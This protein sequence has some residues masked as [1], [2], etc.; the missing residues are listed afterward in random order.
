MPTIPVDD[1]GRELYYE[2]TGAPETSTGDYTTV[3]FLHGLGV[4][5]A[6][7]RP[8]FPFAPSHNARF[9][10]VNSREYSGSSKFRPDELES[11]TTGNKDEQAAVISGLGTELAVF[12]FR[13]IQLREIPAVTRNPDGSQSGGVVFV[14]WSFGCV[15]L[16]SLLAHASDLPQDIRAGLEGYLR[17]VVAYDGSLT[18]FGGP[19]PEGLYTPFRDPSIP[20]E[21]KFSHFMLLAS[22]YQDPVDNLDHVSIPLLQSRTA[23]R[24]PTF[25]TLTASDHE[26]ISEPSAFLAWRRILPLVDVLHENTT[27]AYLNPSGVWKDVQLRV[28]WTDSSA[29]PLMAA[30][31]WLKDRTEEWDRASNSQTRQARFTKIENA[32]HFVHWD[33]PER[34]TNIL[35]S[36]LQ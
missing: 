10:T 35:M 24:E 4:N 29:W 3:V 18:S 30:A 5:S 34:F 25:K 20:P 21:H 16:L 22:A 1:N 32:N 28:L 13:F 12:L 19:P 31:K 36:V 33:E 26:T 15:T 23:I 27:R 9:V 11:L 8:L 14:T 17:M 7:Y 2:D 6:S